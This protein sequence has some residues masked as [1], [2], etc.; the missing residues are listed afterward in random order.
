MLCWRDSLSVCTTRPPMCIRRHKNDHVHTL[1]ILVVH[2]RVWWITESWRK[3]ACTYVM[4]IQNCWSDA[5]LMVLNGRR[6]RRRRALLL[7]DWFFHSNKCHLAA[8]FYLS[9]PF[10]TQRVACR[11]T[12]NGLTTSFIPSLKEW[13]PYCFIHWVVA[14][15]LRSITEL[16]PAVIASFI[17][18]VIHSFIHS[19]S[20]SSFKE[21]SLPT[22]SFIQGIIFEC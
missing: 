12:T 16:S 11:D 7:A 4:T 18:S 17:L 15:W 20:Q 8:S 19:V 13:S 22:A 10:F 2:V 14:L 6:K 9:V 1:K 3:R 5:W 21:S